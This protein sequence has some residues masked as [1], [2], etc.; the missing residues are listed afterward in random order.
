MERIKTTDSYIEQLASEWDGKI[1]ITSDHGMHDTEEGGNHG[2][3]MF[4]DMVVP[5]IL[6]DGGL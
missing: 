1:I 5:Y 4:E 6:T 2:E 3:F